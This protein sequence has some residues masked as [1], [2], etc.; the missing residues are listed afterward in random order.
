[1]KV[2]WIISI[3]K[4]SSLIKNNL[5][6]SQIFS[7]SFLLAYCSFF[8]ELCFAQ[9]LSSLLGGTYLQYAV[10]IGL[11]TFSLGMGTLIYERI[12]SK[13][14]FQNIFIFI[15]LS[16]ILVILFSPW[17]MIYLSNRGVNFLLYI[18]LIL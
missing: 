2:Q 11:F 10:S 7:L 15:E 1:M 5:T 14:I 17:V 12:K 6:S 3:M 4:L 13:Y 9:L 18:P 16:I 8:Y